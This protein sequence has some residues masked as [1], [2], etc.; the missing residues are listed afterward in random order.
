[1]LA[2]L[3]P[4]SPLRHLVFPA[5]AV[6]LLGAILLLS[7]I[8]RAR[9]VLLTLAWLSTFVLLFSTYVFTP[10]MNLILLPFFALVPIAKRYRQFLAFDILTAAIIVARA[11]PSPSRSWA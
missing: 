11:S 3:S 10:Q 7:R 6:I 9:A 1:M 2:F 5:T 4:W 8:K